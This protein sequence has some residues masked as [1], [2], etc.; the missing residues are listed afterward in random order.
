MKEIVKDSG[1]MLCVSTEDCE[2]IQGCSEC[3][4]EEGVKYCSACSE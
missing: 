1:I 2:E 4:K 3:Y